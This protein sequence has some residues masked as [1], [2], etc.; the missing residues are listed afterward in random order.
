MKTR[1]K[2]VTSMIVAPRLLHR[3]HTKRQ[4]RLSEDGIFLLENGVELYLWVG[5][6]ASPA[7]VLALF[8][9]PSLEGQDLSSLQVQAEG[10]D[11]CRRVNTI[12]SALREERMTY[13]KVCV[14][15]CVFKY[16]RFLRV[17]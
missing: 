9:I 2:R 4:N 6:S 12:I 3:A 1:H 11:L 5:P 14:F 17:C 13:L 16:S 8:G 15:M 10:N 7:L